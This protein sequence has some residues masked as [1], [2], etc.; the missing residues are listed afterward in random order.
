MPVNGMKS[1]RILQLYCT[2]KEISSFACIFFFF[3]VMATSPS[4]ALTLTLTL[5]LSP[6]SDFCVCLIRSLCLIVQPKLEVHF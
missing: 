6:D 3:N 4:Q 1:I 2:R 5:D